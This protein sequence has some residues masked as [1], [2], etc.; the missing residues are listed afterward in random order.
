MK[1]AVYDLDGTL[2]KFNTFKCWIIISFLLSICCLRFY[3]LFS[4]LKFVYLRKKK[5]LN[6]VSFKAAVLGVQSGS[7]FWHAIGRLYG[8]F[9]AKYFVRKDLI[10][11]DSVAERCLATAAPGIYALPFAENMNIF[12]HVIF[13]SFT[14]SG[15]FVETLNNEKKKRVMLEFS[16]EPDVFYTDHYDDIPLAK[17]CK[18]TYLVSPGESTVERFRMEV[19]KERYEIVV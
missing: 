5:V 14:D 3:F 19:E 10:Q 12:S 4:F 7:N 9:L 13:S 18:F 11:K 2:I 16:S 6:R 1:K 17:V 15:S 8:N